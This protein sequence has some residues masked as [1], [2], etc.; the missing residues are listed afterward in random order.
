M[1]DKELEKLYV[2]GYNNGYLLSRYEPQLFKK[3]VTNVQSKNVY[4][5]GLEAG[6]LAH[7]REVY[8]ENVQK[9]RSI[10]EQNKPKMR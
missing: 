10:T 6:G 1:E 8:M 3:V 7:A 2:E 4:H 5:S 9:S